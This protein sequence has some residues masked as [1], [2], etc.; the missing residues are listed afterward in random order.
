MLEVVEHGGAGGRGVRVVVELAD[1]PREGG[2]ADGPTPGER[3]RAR[4]AERAVLAQVQAAGAESAVEGRDEGLLGAGG[5][6]VVAV[7]AALV[8]HPGDEAQPVLTGARLEPVG[9]CER[10]LHG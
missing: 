2:I 3:H 8:E 1:V 6:D 9:E 7:G 4:Q 10:I 5:V